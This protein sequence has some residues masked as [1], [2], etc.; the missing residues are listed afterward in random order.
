MPVSA[1]LSTAEFTKRAAIVIALALA[2]ILVWLLFDAILII[3]GAVP[4]ISSAA[5]R[6]RKC[7]R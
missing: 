7:R 6:S 1:S 2:P 3:I 4:V 5:G